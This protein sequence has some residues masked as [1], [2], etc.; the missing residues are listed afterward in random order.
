MCIRD[1]Y[2]RRVRADC[3][4]RYDEGRLCFIYD[5]N[6]TDPGPGPWPSGEWSMFV[7]LSYFAQT[8][9]WFTQNHGEFSLLVH[10]NSGC[11]Y[12]DHSIWALWAG[13]KWPLNFNIFIQNTQTN[14]FD[15]E[16]GDS[17]NPVCLPANA[18]CGNLNADGPNGVCCLGLQCLCPTGQC[19]C[20]KPN[21]NIIV[22]N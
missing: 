10:P 11:E 9:P 22:S 15:A 19:V 21:Q 7:P 5:H 1:R 16:R 14:E 3:D 6:I 8:I 18:V 17:G 13:E 20:V 12:E 4:G 2:Q